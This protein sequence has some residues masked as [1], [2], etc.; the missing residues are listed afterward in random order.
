VIVPEL[1]PMIG[2]RI[3]AA[4][5]ALD[6]AVWPSGARVL[7]LAPDDVFVIGEGEIELDDRH[8]IVDHEA[9]F[10]GTWVP[11]EEMSAWLEKHAIW[12]LADPGHLAQGMAAHLPIKTIVEGDQVLVVTATVVAHEL[13]ER[14]P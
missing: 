1:E 2:R 14:L 9:G 5:T 13:A 3:N 8:A 10:S 4:P 11:L 6:T 12:R 7:R